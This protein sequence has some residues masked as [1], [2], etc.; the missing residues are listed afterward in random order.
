MLS[1]HLE[2][3]VLHVELGVAPQARVDRVGRG[4]VEA[5]VG[6][7]S[8]EVPDHVA[9]RVLDGQRVGL[10]DEAALRVLEV[11]LVV[12]VRGTAATA[13]LA[14]LVASVAGLLGA[15][16]GEVCAIADGVM[17]STTRVSK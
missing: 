17:A 14:A 5:D 3:A 6:L 7:V 1:V 2:Q 10:A 4:L 11:R 12:E 9:L 8:L 16:G 13:R 15:S